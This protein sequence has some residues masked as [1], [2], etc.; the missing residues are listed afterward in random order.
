MKKGLWTYFLCGILCLVLFNSSVKACPTV[1]LESSNISILVGDPLSIQL[2]ID[3]VTD[4]DSLGFR[5]D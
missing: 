1:R 4:S 5:S 2:H 3:G